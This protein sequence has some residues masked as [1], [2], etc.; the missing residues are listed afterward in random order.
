MGS[1]RHVVPIV[2]APSEE[3][4]LIARKRD[5]AFAMQLRAWL[6]RHRAEQ[7]LTEVRRPTP[8]TECYCIVSM[9]KSS[10]TWRVKMGD[11]A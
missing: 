5:M 3:E 2:S 6:L 1:A 11:W 7:I 8:A 9:P 10:A 4:Q